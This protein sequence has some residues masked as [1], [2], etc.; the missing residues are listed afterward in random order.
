MFPYSHFCIVGYTLLETFGLE[1]SYWHMG[2]MDKENTSSLV[3][4]GYFSTRYFYYIY[5][6]Y[7]TYFTYLTRD[8]IDHRYW[9][10]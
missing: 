5:L 10:L 2:H 6:P 8:P 1:R 9:V 3:Y 7:S 4:D